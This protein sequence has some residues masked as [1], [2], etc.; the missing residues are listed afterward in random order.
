MRN[1]LLLSLWFLCLC[2]LWT[3]RVCWF[4]CE[5]HTYLMNGNGTNMKSK[6]R[7]IINIS[8]NHICHANKRYNESTFLFVILLSFVLHPEIDQLKYICSTISCVWLSCV[9]LFLLFWIDNELQLYETKT[10]FWKNLTAKIIFHPE[11]KSLLM[12]LCD[13][14]T[15]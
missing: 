3:I 2:I 6:Y 13:L 5:V 1:F 9:H 15:S 11:N 12:I 7:K 8:I 4:V 10:F 14:L